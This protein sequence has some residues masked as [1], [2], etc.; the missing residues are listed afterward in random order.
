MKLKTLLTLLILVVNLVAFSQLPP[1]ESGK[2]GGYLDVRICKTCRAGYNA[3]L[4]VIVNNDK[5]FIL[6][7]GIA[8]TSFANPNIIEAINVY[9]DKAEEKY[10]SA[11]KNGVVEITLKKENY[12]EFMKEYKLKNRKKQRTN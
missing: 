12:N 3:P 9:K 5:T 6:D 7:S 10:G 2:P 1:F 8:Y 11:A 4:F